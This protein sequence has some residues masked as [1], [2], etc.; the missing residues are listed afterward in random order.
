LDGSGD[1]ADVRTRH[2]NSADF[3]RDWRIRSRRRDSRLAGG[4]S[5]CYLDSMATRATLRVG[6]VLLALAPAA[7]AHA[8]QPSLSDVVHLLAVRQAA[9]EQ[10]SPPPAHAPAPAPAQPTPRSQV[11]NTT[12]GQAP[13]PAKPAPSTQL[14][15][16]TA[17][18]FHPCRGERQKPGRRTPAQ[19]SWPTAVRR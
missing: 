9:H 15:S 16:A 7:L 13:S 12:P 18:D 4:G 6:T 17:Q 11:V 5:S 14:R 19:R 3:F 2:L 8:D 1:R 10:A